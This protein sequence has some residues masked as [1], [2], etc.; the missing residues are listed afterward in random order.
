VVAESSGGWRRYVGSAAIAFAV[1][2]G[3]VAVG[4]AMVASTTSEVDPAM[5]GF[6]ALSI[7][8]L[9]GLVFLPLLLGALF[10]WARRTQG[11]GRAPGCAS[12]LLSAASGILL[13][14]LFWVSLTSPATSAYGYLL[15]WPDGPY[16]VI[17][18]TLAGCTGHPAMAF[19][20]G[21]VG[22]PLPSDD[23]CSIAWWDEGRSGT[24]HVLA[25]PAASAIEEPTAGLV[26]WS[27]LD[28]FAD[29]LSG[30][31][32]AAGDGFA[33]TA[34]ELAAGPAIRID[35]E[36]T[37]PSSAYL[38]TDGTRYYSVACSAEEPPADR[39]LA[40]AE[41]FEFLPEE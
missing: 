4:A 28:G 23:C 36:R 12:I 31:D 32:R 30:T 39:W 33:R 6:F 21:V 29:Y 24:G 9:S 20:P 35:D 16:R 8:V 15:S 40:H 25:F 7:W 13:G 14:S 19:A 18:P 5:A 34:L 27:D 11:V 41:S 26:E 17:L 38:L 2:V 1:G 10:L 37:R 22:E 3:Y